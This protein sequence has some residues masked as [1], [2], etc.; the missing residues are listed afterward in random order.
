MSH[1]LREALQP[2]L[3][4]LSSGRG[5]RLTARPQ[6]VLLD[7]AEGTTAVAVAWDQARHRAAL[8]AL[9]AA[10]PGELAGVTARAIGDTLVLWA[11]PSPVRRCED[12]AHDGWLSALAARFLGAS[13]AVGKNLLVLG[14]WPAA[15]ELIA[16]LLAEAVRP[17]VVGA[18][19]EALPPAWVRASQPREAHLLGADRIGA[20]SLEATEL[21]ALLGRASGVVAWLDARRLERGLMR[22]EAAMTQVAPSVPA[23]LQILS[24]VDLVIGLGDGPRVSE[25]AEICLTEEGY[26]PRLVFAS[27]LPPAPSVL[28][29][30]AAPT[31]VGELAARGFSVL[32]DELHHASPERERPRPA[33]SRAEAPRARAAE[34]ARQEPVRPESR[35]A[36]PEPR[37]E[38]GEA[39][40]VPAPSIEPMSDVPPGWELDQLA[41]TELADEQGIRSA[42]DAALAATFGLGPPPRPPG[43]K[44]RSF[45]DAL[46]RAKERADREDGK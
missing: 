39:S 37:V 5:V 40:G 13:A 31:Y 38:H 26:R 25:I 36:R 14:A 46:Q 45:E 11:A 19:D 17:A 32:A 15:R 6:A 18:P 27:G 1:A 42:D 8:E 12:L 43:V 4:I 44:E 22:L 29:P 20:W 10:G 34:P 28:V 35:D 41:D 30:V 7:R 2:L 9:A 21:V 16:S 23:P 24:S 33:A 3:E